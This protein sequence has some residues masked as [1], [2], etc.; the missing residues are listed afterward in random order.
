[1][2]FPHVQLILEKIRNKATGAFKMDGEHTRE[3]YI[4]EGRFLFARSTYPNERLGNV[5][6]DHNVINKEHLQLAQ[7]NIKE[8]VSLGGALLK[9][10]LV[11]KKQLG[12]GAK[13]QSMSIL[14]Y[15]FWS[16]GG[17]DTLAWTDEIP[18]NI[19]RLPFQQQ[20]VLLKLAHRV[21]DKEWLLDQLGGTEANYVSIDGAFDVESMQAEDS[22]RINDILSRLDGKLAHNQL[23]DVI[24]Q[25]IFSL[26][27]DLLFL[28]WS[29]AIEVKIPTMELDEKNQSVIPD[30]EPVSQ[31]PDIEVLEMEELEDDKEP[32]FVSSAN[33]M[34]FGNIEEESL[35]MEE[36]DEIDEI[37]E[38]DDNE[39]LDVEMVSDAPNETEMMSSDEAEPENVVLTSNDEV[40]DESLS[41]EISNDQSKDDKEE[42]VLPNQYKLPEQEEK[43]FNLEHLELD[44]PIDDP[45]FH[46]PH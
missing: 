10:G 16:P 32:L 36:V 20:D 13:E 8:G 12:F 37:D 1:M 41:Q 11:T 30:E 22:T 24:Q 25:P 21:T 2:E 46:A 29:R 4:E 3:I 39:G 35:E 43:Q 31:E 5:L 19:V 28:Q 40:V 9:L 7:K 44:K 15:M 23:A 34:D 27:C 18:T 6:I 33:E 38:I 45:L 42:F 26:S 17:T 14:E